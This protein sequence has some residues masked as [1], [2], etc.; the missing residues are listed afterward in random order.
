MW[1]KLLAGYFRRIRRMLLWIALTAMCFCTVFYL[2]SL[3]SGAVGYA[4]LLGAAF[5][6]L[7]LA[8]D[9][10]RFR[11]HFLFLE[12]ML[13][14]QE[15]LPEHFPEPLDPLERD[16]QLLA[17][18]IYRNKL[19]AA[20]DN[21]KRYED[22]MDYYT[23]WT[24]QIKT[25]ISAMRL[26]LQAEE[27]ADRNALEMELFEIEQ[28]T[29]MALQYLRLGSASNDFVLQPYQLD[30]MVRQALRKYAKIF[31]GRRIPV[32]FRETGME[33]ITDEKWFVFVIEQLLSN[34]LKYT[35]RGKISIYA[36]KDRCLVIADTGI[37]ISAQDLPRI[38][39]KGYTGFNGR[40][41]KKATGLGLYL[42]RQI[43]DKLSHD[44]RVE[45][46]PGRGTRVYLTK[47]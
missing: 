23:M 15:I 41:D 26:L 4:A 22:M 37:G 27:H 40:T 45:S 9:F 24:H 10:W 1:S 34:A 25:P 13:K 19:D 31:I 2:Y 30:D 8:A 42:C 6:V 7:F 35:D 36:E 46:Q 47:L 38:F 3:P 21:R 44:I 16:Y 29:D 11:R 20:S 14:E 28:Y 39:E 43:L 12:D 18:T 5:G 32:E 17:Q 33:V